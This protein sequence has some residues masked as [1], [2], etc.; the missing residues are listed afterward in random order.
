MSDGASRIAQSRV[1]DIYTPNQTSARLLIKYA[2]LEAE[3]EKDP[4]KK[5]GAERRYLLLYDLYIKARSYALLN[6]F[7]F[8]LSLVF[9]ILVLLWPSFAVVL[10]GRLENSEWFKSVV[11]QTTVTGLAALNYA[12]YSQYKNK[13]TYTENLMRH[14]LF[15]KEDIDA[16]SLKVSEE[17][18]RI[19]KGFSFGSLS[20][21]DEK[22][23]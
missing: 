17:I 16:L 15:S 7:F 18:S 12:F 3:A 4:E 6:K 20:K 14:T 8:L 2:R 13:Q 23:Q 10:G 11:V 1:E 21:R 22:Q 19:D 5:R 9:S